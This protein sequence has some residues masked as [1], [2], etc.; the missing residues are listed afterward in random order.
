[1]G[2]RA[3]KDARWFNDLDLNRRCSKDSMFGGCTETTGNNMSVVY[4]LYTNVH[5]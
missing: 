4:V 3:E 2:V 5:F 1:M